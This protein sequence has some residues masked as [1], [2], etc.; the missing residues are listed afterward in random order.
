V[1]EIS[2]ETTPFS[3]HFFFSYLF[4]VQDRE[5][6]LPNGEKAIRWDRFDYL[7]KK[8]KSAWKE[9]KI[10]RIHENFR[11]VAMA[12]HPT[13]QNDWLIDEWIGNFHFFPMA[14]MAVAEEKELLTRMFPEM[15]SY[16]LEKLMKFKESLEKH[17]IIRK[18]V[19]GSDEV[20]MNLRQMVRICRRIE[21]FPSD[22]YFHSNFFFSFS[23]SSSHFLPFLLFLS[24][25]GVW[26]L[27]EL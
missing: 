10:H 4:P 11:V 23:S 17:S 13:S 27:R 14:R 9:G 5:I 24:F 3:D 6:S 18:K 26:Q 19:D 8:A 21:K 20:S 7:R 16:L 12:S 1:Y 15:S 25:P 2:T 22:L